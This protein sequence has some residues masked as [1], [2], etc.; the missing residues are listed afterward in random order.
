[1]LEKMFLTIL[2]YLCPKGS[3]KELTLFLAVPFD[4]IEAADISLMWLLLPF[5]RLDAKWLLFGDPAEI[6]RT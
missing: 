6:C 3:F 2:G 1:M 4:P 5:C